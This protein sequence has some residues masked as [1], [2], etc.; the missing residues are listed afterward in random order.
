M[1][2]ELKAVYLIVGAD[3]PK[4]ARALA[5]LRA[6]FP[7]GAVERLSARDASGADAVAACNALGLFGGGSR[8]VVVEDVER[9]KAAD[10]RA[11]ADYLATPSPDTVVALTGEAKADGPLAKAVRKSGEVLAYDVPR[12]AL[13]RWVGEQFERL[14]ARADA[15]ACRALVEL[16][17][18]D[19]VALGGE[20]E[21]LATWAA[22]DPIAAE[23]VQALVAT[24]AEDPFA[25]TEAWGRRDVAAALTACEAALE[26][27]GR[28]RRDEVHRLAGAL[29]RH[30]ARVAACQRLAADGVTAREAAGRLRL[31]PYA[32]VKAFEHAARYSEEELADAVVRLAALDH[33]LKGGSRLREELQL[34]RTL[35]EVTAE[36]T[37]AAA[38]TTSG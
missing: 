2:S 18:D 16:V 37:A 14:G 33:G 20:A 31:R 25:L 34:A 1:P 21:K 23:D 30:V 13:A 7:E 26:R 28:P 32:A 22:G 11:L 36:Q 5:R 3:R 9:W 27:S 10:V 19:L 38:P 17:G 24:Q 35:V 8:L 6:R 15:A 12:K 29:A 4:V